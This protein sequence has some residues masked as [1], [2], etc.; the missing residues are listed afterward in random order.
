MRF[1][2]LFLLVLLAALAGF[3]AGT[4]D[5][6]FI[7]AEHFLVQ[8]RIHGFSHSPTMPWVLLGALVV[9]GVSYWF[10]FAVAPEVSGSGIPQIKDVLSGNDSPMRWHWVIPIKFFATLQLFSCGMLLGERPTIQIGGYTGKMISDLCNVK[11]HINTHLLIAAGAAGG[12]AAAFNCPFTATFFMLEEMK[13]SARTKFFNAA[14]VLLMGALTGMCT[15]WLWMGDFSVINLNVVVI[16]YFSSLWWLILLGILMGFC[17]VFFNRS[18]LGFLDAFDHFYGGSLQRKVV[19]GAVLALAAVV[20]AGYWPEFTN[21]GV[22]FV[23]DIMQHSSL[24][25][26]EM[27]ILCFSRYFLF[28]VFYGSGAP[29]GIFTPIISLGCILGLLCANFVGGSFVNASDMQ[30]ILVVLCIG[31]LFSA[32]VRTPMTGILLSMELTHSYEL[33]FALSTV[34]CIASLSAKCMRGEPIYKLLLHRSQKIAA[35]Q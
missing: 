28:M 16:P 10:T 1:S 27:L 15:R 23:H 25:V 6:A 13:I 29:G 20:F 19:T 21:N 33:F 3:I 22:V 14:C 24:G 12:M 11:K 5:V 4:L 34:S 8:W 9:G 17:G 18:L 35:R 30:S 26:M 31:G 7:N 32:S 2:P